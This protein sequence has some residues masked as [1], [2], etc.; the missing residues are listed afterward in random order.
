[1]ADIYKA[2]QISL[3]RIVVIKRLKEKFLSDE[4]II[5]RFV[6]EAKSAASFQHQNIAHIYDFWHNQDSCGIVME[7]IDGANLHQVQKTIPQVPEEIVYHI[8]FQTARAL[9][10]AHRK[11]VIHRDLKPSNVMITK[12]GEIKLMDFGIAKLTHEA[13]LTMPGIYLGTPS[14]MSPEQVVGKDLTPASDIFSFGAVVY[15]L[16][17]GR[18]AFVGTET[19][20]VF[21]NIQK[22]NYAAPRK[23]NPMISRKIESIVEKCL[24][25]KAERRFQDFRELEYI[26][27][28]LKAGDTDQVLT[29]FLHEHFAYGGSG[30]EKSEELES[31]PDEDIIH[32]QTFTDDPVGVQQRPSGYRGIAIAVAQWVAAA[33]LI[34]ALFQM[35]DYY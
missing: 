22:G 14:Y 1:M 2:L 8:A 29:Q 15:E 12:A 32:T 16:L 30:V 33:L 27:Q 25:V 9:R 5:E 11:G 31:V 21:E 3:D 17:T 4:G 26:F 28:R 34:V 10:Y 35:V 18:K 19:K 23:L 7:Y 24:R 6:R 13:S 20:T